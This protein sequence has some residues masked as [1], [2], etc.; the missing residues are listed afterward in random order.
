MGS[1]HIN[2][3]VRVLRVVYEVNVMKR[4]YMPVQVFGPH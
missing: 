3:Q 2:W 4:L 1:L